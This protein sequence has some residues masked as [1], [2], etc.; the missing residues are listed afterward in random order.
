[1][2][3][4]HLTT[5]KEDLLSNGY[6]SEEECHPGWAR[7]E[8]SLIFKATARGGGRFHPSP[9]TRGLQGEKKGNPPTRGLQGGK[10]LEPSQPGELLPTLTN[11]CFMGSFG[12]EP[13]VDLGQI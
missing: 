4:C 13:S 7:T 3:P 5:K 10:G 11:Q 2:S 9:P 8:K 6:H 1:M 12:R